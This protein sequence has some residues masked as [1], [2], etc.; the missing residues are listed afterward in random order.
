MPNHGRSW[1]PIGGE[2]DDAAGK[3]PVLGTQIVRLDFEFL[4]GVLRWYHGDNVQVRSVGRHAVDQDLA[5][6]G[7]ASANLKISESERISAD[8][9]APEELPADGVPCGTT[10]GTRPTS[11]SGLRPFSGNSV[12]VRCSTT[13]PSELVSGWRKG[14]SEV[15]SQ[16]RFALRLAA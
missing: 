10:P 11:A 16:S 7:L 5:L 3:S 12:T 13:C 6:P 8:G 2:V 1:C 14:T 9:I 4:D 15:T